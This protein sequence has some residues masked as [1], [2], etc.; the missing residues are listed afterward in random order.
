MTQRE[1][2]RQVAYTTGES[3]GTIRRRGFSIVDPDDRELDAVPSAPQYF[4]WDE[5]SPQP[6]QL[7][8]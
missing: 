1:L 2:E 5:R 4:D 6:L 3:V 7:V 8:A